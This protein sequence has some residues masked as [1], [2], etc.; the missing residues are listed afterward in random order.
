VWGEALGRVFATPDT[1]GGQPA[2]A[3]L[4]VVCVR[5]G[6]PA[7]D[8]VEMPAPEK[9]VPRGWP[10]LYMFENGFLF[11]CVASLSLSGSRDLAQ[12]FG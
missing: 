5:L 12:R 9:V 8:G 4:E 3:A 2:D 10:T 7:W 6:S 1:H 11:S